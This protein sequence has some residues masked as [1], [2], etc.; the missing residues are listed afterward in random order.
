M[1]RILFYFLELLRSSQYSLALLSGI[2]EI[3]PG[4]ISLGAQNYRAVLSDF[5]L[6]SSRGCLKSPFFFDSPESP[7]LLRR[8][9]Y[10]K[11]KKGTY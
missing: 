3:P 1:N 4:F 6:P 5:L 7:T 11:A 2:D 9:G 8:S 10:A